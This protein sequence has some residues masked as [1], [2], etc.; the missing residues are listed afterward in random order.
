MKKVWLTG[1]AVLGV[2]SLIIGSSVTN[3]KFHSTQNKV[4]T[5]LDTVPKPDSPKSMRTSYYTSDTIPKPD[6]PVHS[7]TVAGF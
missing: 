4:L 2:A 5:I 3:G 6:S 1:F 7:G